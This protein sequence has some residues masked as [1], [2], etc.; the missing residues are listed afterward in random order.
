MTE[1]YDRVYK[2]TQDQISL[3]GRDRRHH[4]GTHTVCDT[5]T[6]PVLFAHV[7]MGTKDFQTERCH[8][9]YCGEDRYLDRAIVNHLPFPLVGE[10]NCHKV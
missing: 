1:L 4:E 6:M 10:I 9:G 8:G 3:L 2:L 5:L 7:H